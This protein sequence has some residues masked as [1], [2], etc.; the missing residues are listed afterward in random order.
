M[1]G[2]TMRQSTSHL[3]LRMLISGF[4]E[5]KSELHPDK[6]VKNS[7][8]KSK[9]LYNFLILVYRMIIYNLRI[10]FANK[11]VWF[12]AG[13]ILFYIGLS[14][15]DVLTNDVSKIEDQFGIFLFSG[16]LLVFYPSV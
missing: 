3:I 8:M 5:K 13:S 16:I 15:I 10:I 4:S 1:S 7:I 9:G 12:L 6:Q 14:F 2:L 11:F